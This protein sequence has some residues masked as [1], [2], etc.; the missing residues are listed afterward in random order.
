MTEP[1]THTILII[2]H[3]EDL[4]K[5]IEHLLTSQGYG[6]TWVTD[7]L[8]GLRTLK[9]TASS[10]YSLVVSSYRMP[11]MA[12]D[13]ILEK[14]RELSPDTRRMLLADMAEIETV[15]N[16]INRAGIHRCLAIP[17]DDDGFVMHVKECCDQFEAIRKRN[18][19]KTVTQDQ[20][21]QMYALARHFKKKD[22]Q[23]SE[24]IS[25]KQQRIRALKT[26]LLSM[27]Q[28]R[29]TGALSL[30]ELMDLKSI[31]PS[32]E[33]FDKAFKA[34]CTRVM[35][36]IN[37]V[38]SSRGILLEP[39]DYNVLIRKQG[40]DAIPRDLIAWFV[41]FLFHAFETTRAD[42]A[43]PAA[44]S[45]SQKGA[46]QEPQDILPLDECVELSF[47]M[48]HITA[49]LKLKKRNPS[50]TME[51]LLGYLEA[52]DVRFGV[53]DDQLI[54]T[55]LSGAEENGDNLVVAKGIYP[56]EPRE[57]E[58]KYHFKTDFRQAGKV[59]PDGSI[60]FRD[61]GDIPFVTAGTLLAEKTPAVR[62]VPGTDVSGFQISVPEP[63]DLVFG[64]GQGTRYSEDQLQ[65]YADVD[66]QPHLDALGNISVFNELSIKGD[67]D[68]NT[69]NINF[70]GN[71]IV[72]GTVREG[73]K[74]K[75]ATLTVGQIEGA[76]I[77]LTGDLNVGSGIID[78]K[79]I[80]VQGIV[81]AKYINNSIIK[82]F[83][84]LIVQ[85]EIIDSKIFLGGTCIN[86]GG[87][88]ISSEVAA[89]QGVQAGQIGTEVSVPT[90]LRVGKDEYVD[91]Q[92][93]I[94]ERV[95][96]EN[97]DRIDGLKAGIE[98]LQTEDQQ[99][100]ATI[101]QF[102]Y[103]QDRSQVELRDIQKKMNE[104]KATS[105]ASAL[106]VLIRTV[107]ALNE[108]ALEAQKELD[109]AFARQDRIAYEI[110][111]EKQVIE[112]I[113]EDNKVLV[114]KKKAL[115]ELAQRNPPRPLITVGKKIMAGTVVEAIHSMIKIKEDTSRC[116]IQEVQR[117]GEEEG[118]SVYFELQVNP[119]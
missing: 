90:R 46:D 116:R 96:K 40:L 114:V 56:E 84:D 101:S 66:G 5:S 112:D 113:E 52:C 64:A 119:L 12:G 61:R 87:T 28:A 62:G 45:Q 97:L 81:Q 102:A 6:V 1:T 19:L 27:E 34:L 30:G 94:V 107:K 65:I 7:S 67:V 11:K 58:I 60:D 42:K 43:M 108:K 72:E 82:A 17:L 2:E 86:D 118:G 70:N 55:W 109:Q 71:I 78:A 91:L 104:I 25:Q 47:S 15:V 9:D 74:V 13:A 69:G 8:D 53:V 100:N 24:M 10:P 54:G 57:A 110:D 95:L 37:S 3:N 41:D 44:A 88:I 83:G 18:R 77:D 103:V 73:F 31:T 59:L 38:T 36:M 63:V 79:L 106:K 117:G 99:L 29:A 111:E 49:M 85:K 33:H 51:A 98:K 50:L 26:K 21:Q 20:N 75:G 4:G 16:A 23:F 39:A 76:E 80:N 22:E 68:Y 48:D 32:S 14:V 93:E 115:H 89:K 105:D 35:T 92:L